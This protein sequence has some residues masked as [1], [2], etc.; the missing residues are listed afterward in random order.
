[1][2]ANNRVWITPRGCDGHDC[3]YRWEQPSTRLRAERKVSRYSSPTSMI[4]SATTM[5]IRLP[6][7]MIAMSVAIAFGADW[8]GIGDLPRPVAATIAS[9]WP[10]DRPINAVQNGRLH[11][12]TIQA[13]RGE[14]NTGALVWFEAL[15][16]DDGTWVETREDI[17]VPSL[18]HLVRARASRK[19]KV[20]AAEQ[21]TNRDRTVTYDVQVVTRNW[22]LDLLIDAS[23]RGSKTVGKWSNGPD[24]GYVDD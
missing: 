7:S 9:R 13:A 6:V 23:G 10:E 17:A 3:K 20:Y 18:P 2:T 21:W 14:V 22:T 5:A 12:V 4:G 8:T 19:G 1:V 16:T 11:E 24:C 15:L